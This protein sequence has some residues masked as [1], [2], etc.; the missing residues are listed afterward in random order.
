MDQAGVEPA[1][2]GSLVRTAG[3]EPATVG[4]GIQ[5]LHPEARANLSIWAS[6]ADC[7]IRLIE[8]IHVEPAGLCGDD[9]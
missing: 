3:I 1:T 4:F 6:M 5:R 2:P 8:R 7:R 9:P